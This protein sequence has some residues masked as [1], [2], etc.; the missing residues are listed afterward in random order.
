MSALTLKA[1]IGRAAHD[2]CCGWAHM[3]L[4]SSQ[5]NEQA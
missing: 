5:K 3:F 2:L 1:D 4:I